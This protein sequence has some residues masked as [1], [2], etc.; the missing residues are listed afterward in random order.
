MANDDRTV[1]PTP[2]G[3][4]GDEFIIDVERIQTAREAEPKAGP[5][6]P[7]GRFYRP[8]LY[9]KGEKLRSNL[10]VKVFGVT[11]LIALT[12][13]LLVIAASRGVIL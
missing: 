7:K 4:G 10:A 3:G 11:G 1:S 9:S 5:S 8:E 12:A 6:H 13:I 2:P